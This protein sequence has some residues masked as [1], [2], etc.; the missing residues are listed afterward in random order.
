MEHG[1]PCQETWYRYSDVPGMIRDRLQMG[2]ASM[3][4]FVASGFR[5]LGVYQGYNTTRG[6]CLTLCPLHR[7]KTTD[8]G[9]P[10][11]K[12]H[13]AIEGG[14]N[15]AALRRRAARRAQGDAGCC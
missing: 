13:Q 6:K 4:P 10:Q 5:G 7:R 12:A 9:H 8:E 15:N 3:L 14:G 11:A 1:A 2:S